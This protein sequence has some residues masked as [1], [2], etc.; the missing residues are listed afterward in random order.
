MRTTRI[1]GVLAGTAAIALAT[2]TVAAPAAAATLPPGQKISVIDQ[3]EFDFDSQQ[4]NASPSNAVSTAVGAPVAGYDN[5]PAIDVNDDGLGYAL[6]TV[7]PGEGLEHPVLLKADANTGTL[8]D[9]IVVVYSGPFDVTLT[10][11]KGIDVSASGELIAT[12]NDVSDGFVAGFVGVI[13]P[14]SGAFTSFLDGDAA[15]DAVAVDPATNAI[16][17]FFHHVGGSFA[18]A[19]NRGEN[20]TSVPINVGQP[21]FGADFDRNGQLWVTT[22]IPGTDPEISLSALATLTLV[23]GSTP[24]VVG[25]FVANNTALIDVAAI[26]V[27]GKLAATG[28]T[29]GTEALPV[30]LGSALL[31]LAGAAFVATARMGR[32]R[33]A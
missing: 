16:W 19:V 24:A 7:D 17:C 11:C 18:S 13:D 22:R 4:Y 1:L 20:S 26:T 21:I 6:A 15:I 29:T 3:R 25:P 30:A 23:D 8:T 31:L 33:T 12:C 28:S 14:L 5:V 9:P 2:L 32:R 10:E 27:W